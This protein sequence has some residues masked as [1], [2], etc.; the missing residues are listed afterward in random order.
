MW[1]QKGRP[2]KLLAKEADRAG[3][4]YVNRRWLGGMLT[5]FKTVKQSIQK[6]RDSEALVDS[7]G[8]ERMSKKEGLNLTREVA[9][10]NQVSVGSK[11][12]KICQMLYLWLTLVLSV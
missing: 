11:I 10:L 7:G 9:K 4:P 1:V 5:N 8:L 3:M 6:L 12:W 2:R